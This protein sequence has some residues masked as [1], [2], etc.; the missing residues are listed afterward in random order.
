MAAVYRAG[1]REWERFQRLLHGEVIAAHFDG[2]DK[3]TLVYRDS[4][5]VVITTDN[6]G[7]TLRIVVG[8][9]HE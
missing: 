4:Y 6:Y 8:G 9:P 2:G 5:T 3:L 1:D 7:D